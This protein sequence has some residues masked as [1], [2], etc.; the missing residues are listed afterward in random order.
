MLP[1]EGME[2]THFSISDKFGN[3]VSNTYTI[4]SSYGAKV[5]VE[6]LGFLLNNGMDDFAAAPGIPNQ[7]GLL[8][9]E[10]NKI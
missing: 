7:F 2:T 1:T 8:G 9:G 10:A 4:N 6:G 5:V 3:T